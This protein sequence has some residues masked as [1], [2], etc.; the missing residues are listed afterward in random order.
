VSKQGIDA[1]VAGAR[2]R[3]SSAW[4]GMTADAIK[5]GMAMPRGWADMHVLAVEASAELD[6]IST[7]LDKLF[8]TCE[9]RQ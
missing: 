5:S 9:E 6:R 8:E 7:Q 3:R 4:L 1:G 2:A